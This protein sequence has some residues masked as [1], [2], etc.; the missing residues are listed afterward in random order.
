M[1]S[2]NKLIKLFLAHIY[3]RVGV[4]PFD[5]VMIADWES[6]LK[7][8]IPGI[9]CLGVVGSIVAVIILKSANYILD[10]VPYPLILHRNKSVKQAY[11]LGFAAA[12]IDNDTTG[13]TL[14]SMLMRCFT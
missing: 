12:M 4:P 1:R 7:N 6:W 8:T 11:M 3:E 13:R 2:V 5:D 14:I 9:I 10:F